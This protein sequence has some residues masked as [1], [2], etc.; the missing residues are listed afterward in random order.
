MTLKGFAVVQ[1]VVLFALAVAA[2]VSAQA[3]QDVITGGD[4]GFR[5]ERVDRGRALGR[6]VIRVDGKWLEA[7]STAGVVPLHTK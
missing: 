5:L 3:P 4:V 2:Y 6:L 1:L 7:A